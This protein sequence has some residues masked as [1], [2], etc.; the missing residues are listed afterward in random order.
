MSEELRLDE[1]LFREL[2]Q[3]VED[4]VVVLDGQGKIRYVNYM[5]EGYCLDEVIGNDASEFIHPDY[6]A[7][8]REQ[9]RRILLR[10]EAEEFEVPGRG[11]SGERQ[12]YAGRASPIRRNG[13]VVGVVVVMTN[14]TELRN[15][16]R[17]AGQ[18]KRLLP[19]CPWCSQKVRVGPDQW[20][21]LKEYFYTKDDIHVTHGMCPDCGQ[22][23][24]GGVREG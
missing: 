1:P 20:V 16:R 24:V 7:Q 21:T 22:D 8:H 3:T 10:G 12:W 11:A 18:L 4:S 15:A 2:L 5:E 17:E 23:M 9:L 6:Q 19:V 14:I 13:S